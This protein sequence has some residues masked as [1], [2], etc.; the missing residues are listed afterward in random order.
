MARAALRASGAVAKAAQKA[1]PM[2]LNTQP[3]LASMAW[4]SKAS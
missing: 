3:L 2:V 4:R 1:S